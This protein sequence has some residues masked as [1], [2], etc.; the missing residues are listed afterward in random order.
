MPWTDNTKRQ[1]F[2][3]A[4]IRRKKRNVDTDIDL[5]FVPFGGSFIRTKNEA[6]LLLVVE[7][8]VVDDAIAKKS[9]QNHQS[10]ERKKQTKRA[11]L[12]SCRL[13]HTELLNC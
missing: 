13:S 5:R 12:Y 1:R 7:Y 2:V 6:H 11:R 9:A 10:E 8:I 3:V 4:I